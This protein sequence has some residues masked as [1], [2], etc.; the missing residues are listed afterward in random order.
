MS[1]SNDVSN[2]HKKFLLIFCRWEGSFS[3]LFNTGTVGLDVS[4]SSVKHRVSHYRRYNFVTTLLV[5]GYR[6]SSLLLSE[7]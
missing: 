4:L 2:L 1:Q 3:I 7:H 5:L 6:L